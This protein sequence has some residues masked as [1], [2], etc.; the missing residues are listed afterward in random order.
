M[1]GKNAFAA[2]ATAAVNNVDDKVANITGRVIAVFAGAFLAVVLCGCWV[3]RRMSRKLNAG[4]GGATVGEGAG[5][6]GCWCVSELRRGS[7]VCDSSRWYPNVALVVLMVCL[8]QP[9]YD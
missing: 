2:S 8:S 5:R 4:D 6:G 1:G 3:V 9:W 7:R